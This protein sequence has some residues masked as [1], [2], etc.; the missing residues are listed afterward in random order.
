MVSPICGMSAPSGIW[1]VRLLSLVA[2]RDA[3]R[4]IALLERVLM[5]DPKTPS[6]TEAEKALALARSPAKDPETALASKP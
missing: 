3:A 4:A 6:A 1:N 2:D 5:L